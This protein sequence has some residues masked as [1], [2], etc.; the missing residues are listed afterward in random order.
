[1]ASVDVNL[2]TP[3][4]RQEGLLYTPLNDELVIYD[5][6]RNKAHTLNQVASLVWKH[7]DGQTAVSQIQ[8]NIAQELQAPLD[9]QM[10]WLALQQLDRSRLLEERLQ[11]P[12][13]LISR[14]EAARR[15]GKLAIV[16]VPIVTSLL[17]PPAISANSG[18]LPNG[19]SCTT[20]GECASGCCASFICQPVAACGG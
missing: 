16:A 5:T 4:A 9:E 18:G 3:R 12:S 1:M 11:S 6:E 14:R 7:C 8:K 17:I 15:F 13:N 10:V 20:N 19:A 2:Q